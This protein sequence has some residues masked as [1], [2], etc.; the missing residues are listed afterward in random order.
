MRVYEVV[1]LIDRS[2]GLY[3][4]DENNY[5]L[6][7]DNKYKD[8]DVVK[9]SIVRPYLSSSYYPEF[10]DNCTY[11]YCKPPASSSIA[12]T[13]REPEDLSDRKSPIIPGWQV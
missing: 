6:A 5:I 2:I 10:Y 1:K 7:L 3:L 8:W 9:I 13:I 12:L 4:L 11:D